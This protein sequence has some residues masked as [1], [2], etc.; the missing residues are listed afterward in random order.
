[1]DSW[2]RSP[3]R[4]DRPNDEIRQRL[5]GAGSAPRRGSQLG[6]CRHLRQ[7]LLRCRHISRA[8][9]GQ[10]ALYRAVESIRIKS[11]GAFVCQGEIGSLCPRLHSSIAWSNPP[12]HHPI[13]RNSSG[14]PGFAD[15]HEGL[16]W[17]QSGERMVLACAIDQPSVRS[18][19][20]SGEPAV[21]SPGRVL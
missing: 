21:R 13:R 3:L 6:C 11:Q 4:S 2:S 16:G 17:G 15:R 5:C 7:T 8:L 14:R 10:G 12:H 20:R 1:M 9:T 19:V 18:S